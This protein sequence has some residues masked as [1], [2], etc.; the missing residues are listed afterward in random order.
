MW[1]RVRDLVKLKQTM[2]VS[3]SLRGRYR[4]V[5]TSISIDSLDA[6]SGMDEILKILDG[7]FK[8]KLGYNL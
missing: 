7:K 2:A 3:L 1:Q 8:K 6:D 4:E 5:A